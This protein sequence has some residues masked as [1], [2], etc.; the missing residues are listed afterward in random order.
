ME[1]TSPSPALRH[2]SISQADVLVAAEAADGTLQPAPFCAKT[3]NWYEVPGV[4]P[5][6]VHVVANG[7]VIG[8]YPYSDH[9]TPPSVDAFTTYRMIAE[10]P[11]LAGGVHDTSI[12]VDVAFDPATPV[13][14]PGAVRC[15]VYAALVADHGPV[16]LVLAATTR[17]TYGVPLVKPVTG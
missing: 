17:N 16:P 15:G 13:G 2:P 11:S 6:H 8:G 5:V 1:P 4:S 10:P 3:R 7:N 12:D 9:V 14:A